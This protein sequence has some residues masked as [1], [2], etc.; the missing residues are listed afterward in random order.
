[1]RAGDIG[2]VLTFTV[3]EDNAVVDI[4]SATVKNIVKVSPGGGENTIALGFSTDGTDGKLTY[5]TVAGDFRHSGDYILTLF[6]TMASGS[7]S[8][9][10]VRVSVQ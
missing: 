4:S 9:V 5:V 3:K 6:L 2:T 10:P 7:F 8:S 1:M